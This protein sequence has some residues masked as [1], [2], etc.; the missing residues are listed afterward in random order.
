MVSYPI[1]TNEI[2][3]L[4]KEGEQWTHAQTEQKI[5]SID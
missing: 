3:L 2:K 4:N 5:L 1:K